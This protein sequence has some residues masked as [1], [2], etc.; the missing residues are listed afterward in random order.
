MLILKLYVDS[1]VRE[2]RFIKLYLALVNPTFFYMRLSVGRSF[3]FGSRK[4]VGFRES[5][6]YEKNTL[7]TE[8]CRKIFIRTAR[9][10]LAFTSRSRKYLCSRNDTYHYRLISINYFGGFTKKKIIEKKLEN[11]VQTLFGTYF[12]KII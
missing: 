10:D 11:S 7:W 4:R 5:K 8:Y 9:L 1:R 3:R 2:F 12:L 6:V